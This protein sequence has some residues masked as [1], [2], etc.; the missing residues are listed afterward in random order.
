VCGWIGSAEGL[1]WNTEVKVKLAE[2]FPCAEN[3]N[4]YPRKTHQSVRAT[5]RETDNQK[6]PNLKKKSCRLKIN[7]CK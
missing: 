2:I 5:K 7:G 6:W 1:R 4:H 3:S